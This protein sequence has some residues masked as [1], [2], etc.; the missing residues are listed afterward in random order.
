MMMPSRILMKSQNWEFDGRHV[1]DFAMRNLRLLN[2]FAWR[3]RTFIQEAKDSTV[4]QLL[5][6]SQWLFVMPARNGGHY[7]NHTDDRDWQPFTDIH[8]TGSFLALQTIWVQY[9]AGPWNSYGISECHWVI[10]ALGFKLEHNSCWGNAIGRQM[11]C[12]SPVS[13]MLLIC[14]CGFDSFVSFTKEALVRKYHLLIDAF[15]SILL[16]WIC[17][18]SC[19]IFQWGR[20]RQTIFL[21]ICQKFL[22]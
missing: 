18:S 4:S 19:R 20:T 22:I 15:V 7:V 14:C 3:R 1:C 13:F 8:A 9:I 21:C 2:S 16:P 12:I 6:V 11:W 10:H 17:L 5:L